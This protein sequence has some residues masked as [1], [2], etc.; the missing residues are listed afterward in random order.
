MFVAILA[1]D[2]GILQRTEGI[3]SRLVYFG[4][5]NVALGNNAVDWKLVVLMTFVRVKKTSDFV[6]TVPIKDVDTFKVVK[7]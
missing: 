2:R 6:Q 4:L 7:T 3:I 5:Y 1:V